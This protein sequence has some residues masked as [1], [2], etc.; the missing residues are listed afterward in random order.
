LGPS[1]ILLLLGILSKMILAILVWSILITCLNHSNFLFLMSATR[2]GAVYY[3][4][5]PSLVQ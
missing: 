3:F 1:T 5:D 4:F 2:S